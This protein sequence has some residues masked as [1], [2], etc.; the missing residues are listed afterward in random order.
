MTNQQQFLN[1][2]R[3]YRLDATGELFTQPY[4]VNVSQVASVRPRN[5]L[6]KEHHRST[7][8]LASGKEV[9]LVERFSV[10]RDALFNTVVNDYSTEW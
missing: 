10:V 3:V 7:I 8:V 1:L 5:T 9:D 2:T 6:G 4:T